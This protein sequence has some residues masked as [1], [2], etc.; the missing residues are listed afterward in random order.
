[1][2]TL[3]YLAAGRPVVSTSLPA[4][5]WLDTDLVTLADTPDAFGA[6]VMRDAALVHDP[7]LVRRRREFAA[8]HSWAQRAERFAGLLGLTA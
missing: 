1:M 7:A 4:V 8:R 2:K 3:E 5:R 6:S